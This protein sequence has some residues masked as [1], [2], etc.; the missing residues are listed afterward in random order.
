MTSYKQH[1]QQ[2]K[3]TLRHLSSSLLHGIHSIFPPPKWTGHTGENPIHPKKTRLEGTWE[4][5]K[6]ILGWIFD[7]INRCIQLP[8]KK[9]QQLIDLL[10]DTNKHNKMK[11]KDLD[12]TRGKLIHAASGMPFAKPLTGPFNKA[13]RRTNRWTKI[14]PELKNASKDF[15]YLLRRATKKPLKAS[16]IVPN[17]P[18][19]C[20]T[21][22]ASGLG[23]GG[24][25]YGGNLHLPPTVWRYE[26]PD[27]IREKLVSTK[28]PKGTITNSDLELAGGVM[29]I[30]A[31]EAMVPIEG[32]NTM[33]SCDNTPAVYWIKKLCCSSSNIATELLK[34]LCSRMAHAHF[35][36]PQIHHIAGVQNV[37]ADYASRRF[38]YKLPDGSE[39][40][41]TDHEFLTNFNTKFP[42][43]NKSWRTFHLNCVVASQIISI[44]LTKR[45]TMASWRQLTKKGNAFGTIGHNTANSLEWT[46]IVEQS[47]SPNKSKPWLLSQ[48]ELDEAS[49]PNALASECRRFKSHYIRSARPSNWMDSQTHAT[50]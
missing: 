20:G 24:V 13:V 22:D 44:L 15:Q 9:I 1:K 14:T 10:D 12:S 43:Q 48:K 33:L 29:H 25:W 47:P 50:K 4:F 17:I 11:T 49:F 40:Y 7:G 28:N 34:L 46:P 37:H 41:I 30:I 18:D 23:V 21:H 2:T 5:K 39:H 45:F 6:E 35:P 3:T 31:L 32:V 19:Y 26:W 16:N 42:I 27:C 8:D 38:R 36:P